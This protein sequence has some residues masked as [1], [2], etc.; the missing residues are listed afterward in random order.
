MKARGAESGRRHVGLPVLHGVLP[1]V[2][3]RL[4][5]DALAGVTLAAL[6]IPEVLGFA[7]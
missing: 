1:V 6:A 2:R 5:A 3:P 7:K 4:G